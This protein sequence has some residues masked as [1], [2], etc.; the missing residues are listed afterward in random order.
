MS[1]QD[2]FAFDLLARVA[3]IQRSIEVENPSGTTYR[4]GFAV[5]RWWA[6]IGNDPFPG[7]YNRVLR[8]SSTPNGVP[9]R[10]DVYRVTMRLVAGPAFSGYQ[11]EYED[12]GNMLYTATLN[13]FG[14]E[15]KLSS[16]DDP[17]NNIP[18]QFV[19]SARVLQPD[20]GFTGKNY[21]GDPQSV[22]I[23]LDI[24]LDVTANFQVFRNS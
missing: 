14:R 22:Y 24:P 11:G 4:A 16:P 8:L 13:R 2:T 9:I 6:P 1:N 15:L 21:G 5:S 10:K 12:I 20:N 18:L 23:C 7:F 19:E 17:P 3:D